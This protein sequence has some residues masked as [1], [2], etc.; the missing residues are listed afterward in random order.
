MCLPGA[1]FN[2]PEFWS[3]CGLPVSCCLAMWGVQ[4]R[5]GARMVFPRPGSSC[6]WKAWKR[7]SK[8][9]TPR[10]LGVLGA[11]IVRCEISCLVGLNSDL[12]RLC[13]SL[14]GLDTFWAR[15]RGLSWMNKETT[16]RTTATVQ[17][18][19]LFECLFKAQSSKLKARTSLLPRFSEKRRLSIEL[20]KR[21]RKCHRI[22]LDPNRRLADG[23]TR[24]FKFNEPAADG[25]VSLDSL[26]QIASVTAYL[27]YRDIDCRKS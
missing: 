6:F 14:H 27:T 4:S 24:S 2:P 21:F 19:S 5:G 3:P 12:Y 25:S 22:G 9:P 17:H 1:G 20:W 26:E 18:I 16:T 7:H 13:G 10:D 11:S 8:R 23:H 15:P